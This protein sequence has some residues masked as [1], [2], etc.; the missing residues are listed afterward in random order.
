MADVPQLVPDYIDVPTSL[1]TAGGGLL[2][3][4][5]FGLFRGSCLL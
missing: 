2:E 3:S 4:A 1:R 5:F